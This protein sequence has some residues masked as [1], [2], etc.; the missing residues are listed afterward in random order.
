MQKTATLAALLLSAS[1]MANTDVGNLD[2]SP[3]LPE[4]K[5][6]GFHGQIGLGIA[7]TPEYVGGDDNK[8]RIVPLINVSYN[9]T[10]YFKFNRL[11]G[12]LYKSDNGFRVGGLIASHRGYEKNDGKKLVIDRDSSTMAGVNLAYNKGLFSAEVGYLTDVSDTSEG[13]KSY[14]QARYTFIANR[15]YSLSAAAKIE[16]LDE[17]IVDYYYGNSEST[18]NTSLSLIGTYRLNEKWN[19]LGVITATSL[20]DEIADSPIVEDDSYNSIILGATYSF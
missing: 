1:A 16:N 9:D 12:W 3:N 20:G 13:A 8:T 5:R 15:E 17:D 14:I 2:N 10:F 18:T 19:L 7:N 11:G 6:Q 4:Q